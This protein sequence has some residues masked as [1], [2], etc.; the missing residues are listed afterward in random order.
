MA[1]DNDDQILARNLRADVEGACLLLSYA[2][3]S[4]LEIKMETAKT[5]TGAKVLLKAGQLTG[6]E[7]ALFYLA[8]EEIAKLASPV[9]VDGLNAA[10]E[11][12]KTV[13]KWFVLPFYVFLALLVAVQIYSLIGSTAYK[14]VK[15][16]RDEIEKV[17]RGLEKKKNKSGER[18]R[19]KSVSL[20]CK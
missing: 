8:Y 7:E 15:G 16:V 2:A 4:G 10:S 13:Y 12:R 6:G 19:R 20:I 9:T 18:R 11:A 17:N 3:Q 1:Q 14:N 5:I